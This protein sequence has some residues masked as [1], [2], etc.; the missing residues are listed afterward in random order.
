M[1]GSRRTIVAIAGV[2]VTLAFAGVAA[3]SGDTAVEVPV[4]GSGVEQRNLEIEAWK[5]ALSVD[6]SS[7]V[8]L[9]QLASLHLQRSRETG[10]ESDV[11]VAS[12]Y[13]RRSLANRV[14]RNGRAYATLATALVAQHRFAEAE[15]VVEQAVGY[16]PGVPEYKALLGEVRLELADYEGA[17]PL[18]DSLAPYGN[19]LSIA[20]RLSRWAEM[21]GE[22][23]R[24]YMIMNKA[25]RHAAGRR[26]L[27]REQVAWFHYR[28]GDMEMRRGRL[29]RANAEFQR[30]LELNPSDYRILSAM[31]RLALLKG[32]PREAIEAGEIALSHKV[33]PKTLWVL[34]EAYLADGD[35]VR[36]AE[37]VSAMHLTA[38]AQARY[39]AGLQ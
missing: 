37:S 1:R 11:E 14:S 7:A 10:S 4:S 9:T 8:A 32:K 21:N 12:E 24:A 28:L 29:R 31:S 27:P 38:G 39:A 16:D 35:T 17:R 34:A 25:T 26:D 22:T 13:A 5:N 20:P 23:E 15:N 3:T 36:A 18:F 6:P 2:A 33:E 30:G 19:R